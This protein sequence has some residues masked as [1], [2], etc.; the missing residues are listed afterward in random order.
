MRT[1]YT[2]TRGYVTLWLG[3]C[4]RQMLPAQQ[5]LPPGWRTSFVIAHRLSTILAADVIFV[6]Q[7]GRLVDR[8]THHELLERG[9]LLP[10]AL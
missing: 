9:G 10:H 5:M 6:L 7:D 8:G 3:A 1:I 2:R 4:P